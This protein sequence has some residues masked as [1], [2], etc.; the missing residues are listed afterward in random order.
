M[1]LP[2]GQF[3]YF[4]GERTLASLFFHMFAIFI[5]MIAVTSLK[6]GFNRV[7]RR[8]V[9]YVSAPGQI[10]SFPLLGEQIVLRALS[11][12]SGQCCEQ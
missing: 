4:Q 2:E 9:G 11:I 5:V 8:G 10:S 7:V 12:V 3:T 1:T 6:Q